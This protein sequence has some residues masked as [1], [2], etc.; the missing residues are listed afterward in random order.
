MSKIVEAC[1]C[2]KERPAEWILAAKKLC[3]VCYIK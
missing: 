1:T 3:R 2:C